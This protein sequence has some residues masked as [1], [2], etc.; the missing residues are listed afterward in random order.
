MISDLVITPLKRIN[1][2]KGDIF[3]ILKCSESS[4]SQFGEAYF[5]TVNFNDIK[6]WK[7]HTKMFLNL[8]VAIGSVKF[9]IYDDRKNSAS[10]GKFQEVILSVDNYC[11][12]SVP[13]GLWMAFQGVGE[14][15]NI[16]LNIASIEHDSNE[17]LLKDIS[18]IIYE[19]ST[20]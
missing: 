19:W 4:F 12:L 6:G 14:D 5:S 7:Q 16:L 17:S 15:T 9:V 8:V 18:E 1:N 2:P 20:L 11:R 13:P 10:Y 3:H